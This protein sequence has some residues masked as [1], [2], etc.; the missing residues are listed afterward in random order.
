MFSVQ[1]D[2][3]YLTYM[4]TTLSQPS[5]TAN[6]NDPQWLNEF[7]PKLN[8]P[9]FLGSCGAT[10]MT[11]SALS[12]WCTLCG[13]P[14][15]D[16]T[17]TVYIKPMPE[18]K[19]LPDSCNFA[20]MLGGKCS[21]KVNLNDLFKPIGKTGKVRVSFKQCPNKMISMYMD[22]QETAVSLITDP[23]TSACTGTCSQ[24]YQCQSLSDANYLQV[25]NARKVPATCKSNLDCNFYA[26]NNPGSSS[27]CDTIKGYCM[28]NPPW[29]PTQ[30]QILFANALDRKQP[31]FQ[32]NMLRDMLLT[33]ND[34][35]IPAETFRRI[36]VV[37]PTK[38]DAEG[39][40]KN[41]VN[42]SETVITINILESWAASPTTGGG[43]GG[44]GG[45]NPDA[46]GAS[47]TTPFFF[48]VPLLFGLI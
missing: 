17:Q 22:F 20:T 36:C 31:A 13:C 12:P 9:A 14:K 10:L 3:N 21:F 6:C 42:A 45:D 33:A 16:P 8:E 34:H 48:L 40:G 39:F 25:V 11:N 19:G 44:G 23:V 43:G 1:C 46:S 4:V 35:T 29:S 27:T 2:F 18:I 38:L 37:D 7:K 41:A 47:H 15:F 30:S 28:Y 5:K 26:Q 32:D 24:G